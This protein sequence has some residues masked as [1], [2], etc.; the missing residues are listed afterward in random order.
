MYSN[1]FDDMSDVPEEFDEEF[2]V[3][4][5]EFIDRFAKAIDDELVDGKD[6]LRE[7]SMRLEQVISMRENGP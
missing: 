5:E 7:M 2:Q 1:I 4:F 6:F 3:E